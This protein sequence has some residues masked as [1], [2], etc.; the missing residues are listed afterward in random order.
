MAGIAE[1]YDPEE[2]TG[3]KVLVVVNM[4][5]AEIFGVKSNGM[6]L[7]ASNDED[8]TLTTVEDEIDIGTSVQ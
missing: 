4:E 8:L 6:L 7:A 2:I 1:H 5:P 3:K